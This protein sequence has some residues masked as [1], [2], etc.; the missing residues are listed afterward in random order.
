MEYRMSNWRKWA[1]TWRTSWQSM[2]LNP[3]PSWLTKFELPHEQNILNHFT[4]LNLETSKSRYLVNH[5]IWWFKDNKSTWSDLGSWCIHRG[6]RVRKPQPMKNL[7][8]DQLIEANQWK[9]AIIFQ[10]HCLLLTK[11]LICEN[12]HH[13]ILSSSGQPNYYSFMN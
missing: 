10:F 9:K 2:H 7:E 3:P 8:I 12:F 11:R 1:N 5:Y 4:W 6:S 13:V